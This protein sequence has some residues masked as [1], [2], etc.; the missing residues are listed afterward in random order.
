MRVMATAM[1]IVF[2]SACSDE[3]CLIDPSAHTTVAGT[4]VGDAGAPIAGAQVRIIAVRR[5]GCAM[6]VNAFTF[7]PDP[8][9]A[10]SNGSFQ[11]VVTTDAGSGDFCVDVEALEQGSGVAD[12]LTV[13][14]VPFG[15]IQSP[16]DTTY[17]QITIGRP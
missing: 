9:I 13:A 4:V 16:P 17:V 5:L 7:A 2:G 6:S 3:C 15:P 12:T 1:V 10:D 11:L 8:A 14:A